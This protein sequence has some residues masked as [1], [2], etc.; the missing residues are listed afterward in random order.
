MK[1]NAE[2]FGPK[3]GQKIPVWRFVERSLPI[4]VIYLMVASL[5]GFLMRPCFCDGAD[6]HVR[7]SL[8]A[9]PR[10]HAGRSARSE[11]RRS[12]ACCCLGTSCSSMIL[13]W[14]TT[15]DTFNI[16]KDGV[17]LVATINIRFR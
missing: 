2:S 10:R 8:E 6:G 4:I 13:G 12:A 16:S 14:Q 11:G 9:I 1:P 5:I 3:L 15:T 7:H 17:N